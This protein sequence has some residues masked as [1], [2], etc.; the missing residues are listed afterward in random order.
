MGKFSR[1][2]FD[3]LYGH[4]RVDAAV[5]VAVARDLARQRQIV[6]QVTNPDWLRT[7]SPPVGMVVVDSVSHHLRR[8]IALVGFT[9]YQLE[10][11][12]FYQDQLCP[13]LV[14]AARHRWL[15]VWVHEQTARPGCGELPFLADIFEA[16]PGLWLSLVEEGDDQAERP[17]NNPDDFPP[18]APRRYQVT[19]SEVRGAQS[20]PLISICNWNVL[21]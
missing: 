1:Q 5:R 8:A 16:I 3:A 4:L 9:D 14:T 12:G 17:P 7:Q 10:V 15:V 18:S 21:R 2:R 19:L 20:D 13:L 11:E 6:A